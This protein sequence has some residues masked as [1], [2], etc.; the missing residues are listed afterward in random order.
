MFEQNSRQL[1]EKILKIGKEKKFMAGEM[2]FEEDSY[3]PNFYII[4]KG[5]VEISKR[6]TEGVSKVIAQIGSGEFLGEGTLSG[7]GKKPASA[8]AITD[9]KTICFSVNDFKKLIND[10]SEIAVDF[11]LAVLGSANA[12]LSKTNT[13]LLALYEINQIMHM[14]LDDLNGLA[15]NLINELIAITESNDGILCLK[16][17]FSTT[18]RTIYSTSDN[19]DVNT[20]AKYDLEKTQQISIGNDM[21]LFINLNNLGF[22]A[23]TRKNEYDS[24]QLRFMML[25]AEQAA[26][27]IKEASDK[28]AEKAKRMLNRK[29]YNI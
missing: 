29:Q 11:L 14:H 22:L 19:L 1:G 7:M 23:L 18:Y 5:N 2:I 8:K 15:K 13:K 4:Q 9:V 26:H 16:N 24:D 3:N 6:T 27:I 25:I 17:P 12:R 28:A 20:F 10:E 21:F